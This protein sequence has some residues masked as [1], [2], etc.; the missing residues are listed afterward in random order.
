MKL[1]QKSLSHSLEAAFRIHWI[2]YGKNKQAQRMLFAIIDRAVK[3]EDDGK[4]R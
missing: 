4:K 1:F 3:E 2:S